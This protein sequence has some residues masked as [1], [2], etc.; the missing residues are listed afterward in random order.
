MD[1]VFGRLEQLR[2]TRHKVLIFSEYVTL[3]QRVADGMAERGWAFE[4]LTGATRDRE[5]VTTFRCNSGNSR[6]SIVSCPLLC[7]GDGTAVLCVN[8]HAP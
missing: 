8:Q 3:L 2:S 4:M 1:V 7:P 5:T 6:S